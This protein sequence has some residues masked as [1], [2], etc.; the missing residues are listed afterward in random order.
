MPP[1]EML[2]KMFAEKTRNYELAMQ[3]DA[4]RA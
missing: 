3:S 2:Q 1:G 4:I